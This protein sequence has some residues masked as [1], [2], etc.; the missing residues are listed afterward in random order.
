MA[1]ESEDMSMEEYTSKYIQQ[2]KKDGIRV[3]G[4][5]TFPPCSICGDE[6]R[7][8]YYRPNQIYVCSKCK[9]IIY[10]LRKKQR[11]DDSEHDKHE[12][13]FAEAVERLKKQDCCGGL[14]DKAIDAAS[15]KIGYYDS[16][17]EVMM[18]IALLKNKYKIIPQRKIGR[19]TVDFVIPY[20]R[21]IVEVDGSI[22]HKDYKKM[23]ARDNELKKSLGDNWVVIHVPAEN[24][25]D[26][27]RRAI[28]VNVKKQIKLQNAVLR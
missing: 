8:R 15:T 26:D 5:W 16:V 13:R 4:A 6:V 12:K 28:K 17:P 2:A 23:I 9:S 25:V 1:D 14:W 21:A 20:E 18:A 10:K 27:V 22:Y 19:Y 24:I 3:E 7:I 11:V